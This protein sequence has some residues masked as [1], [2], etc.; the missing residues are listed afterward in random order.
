[1]PLDPL[2]PPGESDVQASER[3][4]A[5]QRMDDPQ[6]AA[7]ITLTFWEHTLSPE[8]RAFP[9]HSFTT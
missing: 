8:V 9:Q 7:R 1:M 5:V 2:R 6:R 3:R 4:F